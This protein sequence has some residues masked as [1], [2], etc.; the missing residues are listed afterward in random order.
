MNSLGHI[1]KVTSYGES[2]GAQVGCLIE[3]CPAGL[4][5]NLD[6]I[7]SQ[8]NR[9]KTNQGDYAS[10]RQED[11]I[12][13]IVS[14]VF[15]GKT[16]GSPIAIFIEN[17]DMRSSDYDELKHV[18]RP[19]HA[20]LTYH[21][22]YQWR[23]HRGGG[24]SSI[25]ITAPLVA[26]GEIALQL[27]QYSM[28]LQV[29]GYVSQIGDIQLSKEINYHQIL[30]ESPNTMLHCPDE[31]IEQQ[32]LQ[33][34]EEVKAA[35]DTL[36]GSVA[37]VVKGLNAGIGEPIFGKL[38]AQLAHAMMSINTAKGFEYGVGMDS[39]SMRGSEHNDS[40]RMK[41]GKMIT[42][43]NKAGGVLGGISNGEDVYFKVFFKPISSI[44]QV[45]TT[46]ND[47]GEVVALQIKGRHDVCA[48]PRAV[49]I[50]EA[51]TNIVLA[52]LFLHAK[53]SNI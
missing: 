11:D 20:D 49:P 15:E 27:L 9:R 35:G 8:V 17:K 52:D 12:V 30:Q 25:R 42:A 16:T 33:L 4:S 22:K 38:Q 7:Q 41:D 40:I 18:F 6:K 51:Y 28:P 43:E 34:I 5:L 1:F 2:H 29:I 3:G 37:C 14:G 31:L 13:K 47:A 46:S 44:Q 21:Q 45:Q 10:T 19:G 50:V 32:M 26:A 53:L 23:D 48:V 24:R 39:A 36:G